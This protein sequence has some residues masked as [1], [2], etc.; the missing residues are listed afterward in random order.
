I[1]I[2]M[3]PSISTLFPYTTLFRSIVGFEPLLF[4]GFFK[5]RYRVDIF[6]TIRETLLAL[7]RRI[8]EKTK[9]RVF[10]C[11]A[12]RNRLLVTEAESTRSEEHTSELQSRE[13]LVCRLLL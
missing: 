9:S 12:K 5:I 4:P 2:T 3:H 1:F 10:I 13:N 11:V 8:S 7:S 6:F